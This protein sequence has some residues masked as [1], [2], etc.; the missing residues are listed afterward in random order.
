M[1]YGRYRTPHS[2]SY[3]A[4]G[5]DI[6]PV[7]LFLNTLELFFPWPGYQNNAYSILKMEFVQN[8]VY[9]LVPL[10]SGDATCREMKAVINMAKARS[11]FTL[12]DIKIIK[13]ASFSY[14]MKRSSCEAA[15]TF[16]ITELMACRGEFENKSTLL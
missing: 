5:S 15:A 1:K 4:V 9:I 14:V 16:I 2:V 11:Y 10:F 3:S 12:H 7:T 6:L 8:I 13:L